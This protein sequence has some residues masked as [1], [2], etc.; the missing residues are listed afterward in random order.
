[1]SHALPHVCSCVF[2]T[3]SC[4]K[5]AVMSMPIP[6]HPLWLPPIIFLSPSDT[7]DAQVLPTLCL[8]R[9]TSTRAGYTRARTH[10][11]Y[12]LVHRRVCLSICGCADAS[13]CALSMRVCVR[14]GKTHVC[15][16]HALEREG[17]R[18]RTEACPSGLSRVVWRIA[19][20]I[21]NK[22]LLVWRIR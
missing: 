20:D 18:D 19:Y 22:Y 15:T 10:A 8:A 3:V 2:A 1:M 12:V 16:R 14:T 4:C 9:C 6:C 21:D 17:R 7:L 13:A 11:C 5:W